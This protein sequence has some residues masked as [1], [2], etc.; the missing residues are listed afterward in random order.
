MGL[1]V[2]TILYSKWSL[3][4]VWSDAAAIAIGYVAGYLILFLTLHMTRSRWLKVV[5]ST[6]VVAW[7]IAG[8][9]WALIGMWT[10]PEV[11]IQCE[12][13]LGEG[14]H[15]RQQLFGDATCPNGVKVTVLETFWFLPGIERDIHEIYLQSSWSGQCGESYLKEIGIDT[16][17]NQA[18][19]F[20]FKTAEG[21]ALVDT[22]R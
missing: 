20:H 6:T 14:Y 17:A 1:A 11:P 4:G 3:R 21:V 16:L 22:L 5:M 10:Y 7:L 13:A 9:W 12:V 19:A 18:Q 8:L 2:L 15:C